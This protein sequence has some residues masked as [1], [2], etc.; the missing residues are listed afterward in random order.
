MYYIIY[1]TRNLINDKIYVGAHQ[2]ENLED[3]YLGSGKILK[4]AIKKYSIENFE[5]KIL[6]QLNS[7]EEMYQ[8]EKEIV[9][10]EFLL[11]ENIYNL[12]EGGKGAFSGAQK[13]K[14]LPVKTIKNMKLAQQTWWDNQSEEYRQERYMYIKTQ[15][16]KENK[17]YGS[18]KE[19]NPFYGKTHSDEQKA[20]WSKNRKGKKQPRGICPYCNK[21]GGLWS[22]KNFHFENCKF[23]K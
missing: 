17:K 21:E 19:K 7:S 8:K 23:K 16:K 14:K 13:G 6:Y 2:T 15:S 18:K 5:R 3:G 12:C 4:Q 20:K 10:E 9:N 11:R 1:E 22:M